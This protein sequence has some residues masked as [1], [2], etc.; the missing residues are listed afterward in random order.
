MTHRRRLIGPCFLVIALVTAVAPAW[1][2]DPVLDQAK[3]L[4]ASASFEEALAAIG[5]VDTGQTAEPEVLLYK[6]LCLLA[7]GRAQEASVATRELVSATPAFAPN[8]SE[9]PPRFQTL[10]TETRRAALPSVTREMFVGARSQYQAKEFLPALKQFE[11]VLA[12]TNDPA[13]KD[14]TDATDLRTLAS[15]FID[16]AQAAIP[17]PDPGP[18]AAAVAPPPSPRVE[19]IVLQ[20]AVIIRQDLPRWAPTDRMLARQ[21]FNGAIRVSIDVTGRV[22][23]AVMMRPT[24]PSYDV[25]LLRAARDWLYKPATRDGQP[26]ASEKIVEVHLA[27]AN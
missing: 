19:P 21:V 13:W 9:L 3:S 27:A 16:L 14:S 12:L 23:E 11:Q 24:Y 7:L 18:P 25:L 2:A 22:T 4:Y 10:W 20:A 17:K 5:R 8:T 1:A 6:A 26:I 15:G